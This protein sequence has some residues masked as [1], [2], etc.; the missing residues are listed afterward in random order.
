MQIECTSAELANLMP[1]LTKLSAFNLSVVDNA[2][3]AMIAR[4]PKATI[5]APQPIVDAQPHLAIEPN[6]SASAP[7]STSGSWMTAQEVADLFG[8]AGPQGAAALMKRA[9][10]EPKK[11]GTRSVFYDRAE[12]ER[13]KARFDDTLSIQDAAELA[14]FKSDF[15][16][17]YH[18]Q[19]RRITPTIVASQTRFKLSDLEQF[20]KLRRRP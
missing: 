4:G 8:Y 2:G 6:G 11:I 10:I 12:V 18:L 9:G 19:N 17:Y 16:V 7:R 14:G 1:L 20:M 3:D 5:P 13:L 15:G